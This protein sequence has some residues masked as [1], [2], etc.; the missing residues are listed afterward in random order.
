MKGISKL[1]RVTGREH[2][3]ISRFLLGIIINIRLPD[4]RSP[5]RLVQAVRAILDFVYLAQYPLH[6]T[7][8]LDLLEDVRQRFHENK[9]IFVDLGIRGDFNLPKLHSWAH[10]GMNIQLYGSSDNYNTEYTERLHIDLAKDAYRSTNMKN[11]FPQMTL[12]LERKE[13]IIRHDQFI[14]WQLRGCPPPPVIKNLHPGIIYNRKLSMAKNP[15]CKA[16][17]FTTLETAYGATFFRDA[18]SRY[19]LQLSDPVLSRAQIERESAG[20][21]VP[22]NAIPVFQNIKFT[23]SDPYGTGGPTENIVDSIHVHPTKILTN[24]SQIPARFNTAL[25]NTGD[26][27]R[28]EQMVILHFHSMTMLFLIFDQVTES[29]K[30]ELCFHSPLDWQQLF[31]LLAWTRP[32]IWH[33]W[34][35]FHP[36]SH[37]LNNI[38]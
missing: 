37:S 5:I 29:V 33:M 34:S 36:S 14:H 38:I 18:L 32:S 1:N 23:T 25:V 21:E 28:Q 6:S 35:D 4:G 10:Y 26:G 7:E 31:Y 13:K 2:A 30:S 17:K 12:W 11:E 20:F 24:G 3:Q 22:F 16:V 27:G 15:T 19:I 9:S 8:T